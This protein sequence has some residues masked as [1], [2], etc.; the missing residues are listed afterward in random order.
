MNFNLIIN[1]SSGFIIT[2]LLLSLFIKKSS[3]LKLV[4]TPNHRKLH[5]DNMPLV[6][7]LSMFLAITLISILSFF[8]SNSLFLLNKESIFLFIGTLIIFVIGL[9]DDR[10]NISVYY[11]LLAQIIA[12]LIIISSIDYINTFQWT[13]LFDSEYKVISYFISLFF[14]LAVINGINFIDGLDG[15]LI[16]ISILFLLFYIVLFKN[17]GFQIPDLKF[18]FVILGILI[19][20]FIFN[21]YPAK[22][23]LGDSG[24]LL[25]G[26]F[27]SILFFYYMSHVNIE[28]KSYLPIFVFLHP[29]F[30]LFY[31]SVLRIYIT[32]GN[33][34]IKL[35]SIL[36]SDRKHI[37]YKLLDY[38]QSVNK[39][40]LILFNLNLFVIV[41]LYFY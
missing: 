34:F 37:H 8:S 35:F 18:I 5:I 38:T 23:F 6:G 16:S 29:I 22:V 7:G 21:K 4:D 40:V 9:L 32:K 1:L 39:T 36:K 11:K 41:F 17:I 26:W 12:S 28:D 30:D 24:S 25:L 2:C 33:I 3:N 10:Y 14:I 13:F 19:A 20:F 15:L 31:V 27:F